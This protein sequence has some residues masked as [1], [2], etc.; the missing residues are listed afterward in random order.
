M[1][2]NEALKKKIT[3]LHREID[4]LLNVIA[5]F[6]IEP[7]EYGIDKELFKLHKEGFYG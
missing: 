7:E 4:N 5:V 2:E 6:D 1:D 3:G